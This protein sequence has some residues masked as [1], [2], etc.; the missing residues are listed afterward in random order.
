[1]HILSCDKH[2]FVVVSASQNFTTGESCQ[3]YTTK[4]FLRSTN[5]DFWKF[6]VKNVCYISVSARVGRIQR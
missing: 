6:K 1:M 5:E 4:C 3:N 2:W